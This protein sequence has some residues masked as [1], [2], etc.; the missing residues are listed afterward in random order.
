MQTNNTLAGI[1]EAVTESPTGTVQIDISPFLRLPEGEKR[2]LEWKNPSV[3]GV[4]RIGNDAREL[5]KRYPRWPEQLAIDVATVAACHVAPNP[6]GTAPGLFYAQIADGKNDK[7]WFEL[8]RRMGHEFPHL[9]ETS[10]PMIDELI[11]VC[12]LLYTRHPTEF[13]HLSSEA[14]AELIRAGEHRAARTSF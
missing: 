2:L 9:K 13:E 8:M 7:L 4:Y 11:D 6:G 12:A 1:L 3:A 10:L 14:L 5:I